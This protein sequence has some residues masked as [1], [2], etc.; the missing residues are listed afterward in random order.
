[1]HQPSHVN[2]DI[3]QKREEMQEGNHQDGQYLI[4]TADLRNMEI[5]RWLL[6]CEWS[7]Q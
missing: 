7:R 4:H 6:F 3:E 5:R 2:A 1:M